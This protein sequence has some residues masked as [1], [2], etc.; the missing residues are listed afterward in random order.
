MVRIWL[1]L[2]LFVMGAAIAP[3]SANAAATD[4]FFYQ[5]R[6]VTDRVTLI[7]R[8]DPVRIPA[9][10]NVT[11]I[12]QADGLVVIDAG[13]SRPGG[14]RIVALIHL[15]NRKPVRFLV[16]TH[17]HGDHNLGAG[18]FLKAWP[19]VTIISTGQT[20]ANMTGVPMDYIKTYD[21]A[22]EGYRPVIESRLADPKISASEKSRWQQLGE[23]L[24]GIVA[25]YHASVAY[26]ARLT[27]SE[28][29]T[30]NDD[31]APVDL[32]FLGRAN[33]DGDAVAWLPKQRVLVSGD[34]V[35]APIPYAS[36]S[37]PRE[38]IDV[39]GKLKGFAFVDLIPGH[40]PV[41]TD[42]AYLDKLISALSDI[43]AQVAPLVAK[44][45]SLDEVRE[46][47]RTDEMIDAFAGDDGWNRLWMRSVFMSALISN[48][49]KEARNEPI[50]QGRDGG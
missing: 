15:L 16:Y 22:Y 25:A 21:K 14:K 8:P 37:F 29:L 19:N 38:W 33:T 13:G 18:A 32:M 23:D 1:A 9:E 41:Q 35:V 43:R 34:I 42:A 31:I 45:A 39:L 48:A 11:V 40:G 10:G 7:Y 46:A 49:Y 3:I 30:L 27:F 44:G 6:P 12:E 50:L 36:A 2:G 26:P 5:T 24:P 20:R 4:G 47:V 17:Y 28:R